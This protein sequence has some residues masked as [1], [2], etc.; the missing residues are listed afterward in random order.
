MEGGGKGFDYGDSI[1]APVAPPVTNPTRAMPPPPAYAALVSPAPADPSIISSG[2]GTL[3]GAMKKCFNGLVS[4]PV[5]LFHKQYQFNQDTKRII[6]ATTPMVLEH[7]IRDIAAEAND[8]C[9]VTPKNLR[10]IVR[11][12]AKKITK[13]LKRK[14]ESLQA[15]IDKQGGEPGAANTTKEK[16][17]GKKDF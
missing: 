17:K 9:A 11:L 7:S 3:L 15:K 6:A 10:G 1:P 8:E 4:E 16:S 13:D 14:V 12:E 5:S 2:V